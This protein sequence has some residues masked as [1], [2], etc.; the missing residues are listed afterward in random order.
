M[1]AA[2]GGGTRRVR[3]Y[4]APGATPVLLVTESPENDNTN[5]TI[6]WNRLSSLIHAGGASPAL[7]AINCCPVVRADAV[8]QRRREARAVR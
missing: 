1:T 8:L 5:A 6:M 2:T 4:E 3:V 7:R